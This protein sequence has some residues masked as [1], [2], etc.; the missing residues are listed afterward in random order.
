ME[1]EGP[2]NGKTGPLRGVEG[3]ERPTVPTRPL[4]A[5]TMASRWLSLLL[6]YKIQSTSIKRTLVK[7]L[8]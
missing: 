4:D 3:D 6:P 1:E 7:V 5:I 2:Y 8:G